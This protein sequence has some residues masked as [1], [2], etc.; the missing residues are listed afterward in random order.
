LTAVSPL[1]V[2]RPG[3]VLLDLRGQGFSSQHRAQVLPVK[4]APQGI[5]IVRQKRVSDSLITI[6]VELSEAAEPGDYG[7]AVEDGLGARTEALVFK[8]TK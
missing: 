6:L 7:I 5:T 1:E 4:K 3:K 2:K 8:V